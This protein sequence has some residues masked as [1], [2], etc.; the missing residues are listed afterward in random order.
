MQ[1]ITKVA[2]VAGKEY[3]IENALNQMEVHQ[4]VVSPFCNPPDTLVV[5]F[6]PF[7]NAWRGVQLEVHE[8]KDTKTYI[9]KG[10]DEV[11]VLLDEHIV[12]TQAMQFSAFKK[13]F[14]E[15][16]AAW[17]K[18]LRL[19]SE[20]LD[21]WLAVQRQ[22]LSLQ[23][24]FESPDINK[25]LPAEGK[26]FATVNKTWRY[27]MAQVH[28]A[29]EVLPFC[30]NL[31]ILQKLTESNKLLEMVQKRL[32]DYLDKK[33]SAF[34]RFY[35]LSNDEL[36]QILSQT[37]DPTAVQPHLKKCFENIDLLDFLPVSKE[38]AHA[39]HAAPTG[40]AASEDAPAEHHSKS[41]AR[42]IAGMISSANE[43]VPFANSLTTQNKN[44]EH[45]LGEVE[46]EMKHTLQ[47]ELLKSVKDYATKVI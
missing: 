16:I 37:Q 47:I 31:S 1:V 2:D 39:E 7:Q 22:W 40:A 9:V 5:C 36:L 35:F 15:R 14:E 33:R 11:M 26:R 23:P 38:G 21:V 19:V 34:A 13:H 44:V 41:S 27:I 29:P 12:M 28:S 18:K 17:D 42:E 43:R 3:Q 46:S 8:Y 6:Q 24:I 25:Q 30:D 20:V 10:V 32:T 45:W 4:L